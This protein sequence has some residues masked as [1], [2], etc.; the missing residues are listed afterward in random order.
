MRGLLEAG[1]SA[2]IK[3]A[4]GGT[5][6]HAVDIAVGL[7]DVAAK[8]D[9]LPLL[10]AALGQLD[11]AVLPVEVSVALLASSRHFSEHLAARAEF[12]RQFVVNLR[13]RRHPEA[14]KLLRFAR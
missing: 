7:V 13:T 10:N 9:Q 2:I 14:D 1:A 5:L 11:P 4:S 8:T 12:G 3:S 6:Q